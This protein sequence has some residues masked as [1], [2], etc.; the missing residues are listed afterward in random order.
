MSLI[1]CIYASAANGAFDAAARRELLQRARANNARLGVSGI[2]LYVDGSFFQVLEGE[3]D[4][5]DELFLRIAGDTRHGNVTEI[6]REPI[7]RRAFPD[8]SMGFAAVT[9]AELLATAGCNDF[10]AGASCLDRI[11]AGRAKKILQAFASGRWR[12]PQASAGR[13]A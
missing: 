11:D 2:L 5:V 7:V 13:V 3:A 1:H 4:V 10:F 8:W 6:I 9:S 12:Q